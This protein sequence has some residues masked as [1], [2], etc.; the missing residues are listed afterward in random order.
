MHS[1]NLTRMVVPE[2]L[3]LNK[4]RADGMSK[5]LVG[6]SLF[7]E[8][9]LFPWIKIEITNLPKYGV[10]TRHHVPIYSGSLTSKLEERT[11]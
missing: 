6:A 10:R 11:A 7:D 3:H 8:Q 5:I 2:P 4:N 9:S 1:P